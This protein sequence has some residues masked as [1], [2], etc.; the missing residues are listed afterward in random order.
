MKSATPTSGRKFLDY[1]GNSSFF[2]S[3]SLD[4]MGGQKE[5]LTVPSAKTAAANS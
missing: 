3:I 5:L 2:T 1:S 4:I